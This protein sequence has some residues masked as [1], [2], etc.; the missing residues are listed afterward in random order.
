MTR[1]KS[2]DHVCSEGCK[3]GMGA[4]GHPIPAE[5]L[6]NA[7]HHVR[8]MLPDI[9]TETAMSL[10]G[11]VAGY[12]EH[13]EPYE[14]MRVAKGNLDLTGTYRLFAVLLAG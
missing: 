13:D 9:S 14:A 10:I 11:R 1:L 5:R 2:A 8:E 4:M 12:L 6:S 3:S 7:L